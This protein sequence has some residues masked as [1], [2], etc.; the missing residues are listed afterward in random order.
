MLNE[1]LNQEK[2][3]IIDGYL[4]DEDGVCRGPAEL[5]RKQWS[6]ESQSDLEW[7][8][9]KMLQEEAFIAAIDQTDAVL[10]AKAVIANAEAM[11]KDHSN[12]LAGLHW[13]FDNE[14][15]HFVRPLIEGQKS[16]TFKTLVGSVSF[17]KVPGGLRVA[18][19]ESALAVAEEFY[20]ES[21]KVVRSFLVSQLT[22][23]D[24]QEIIE[25]LTTKRD[26]ADR[27]TLKAFEIKPDAET[28]TI[29]TGVA[30]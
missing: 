11:K 7:I 23:E 1:T 4:Y 8:L 26:E 13:R 28:M 17:R 30:K 15:E 16:K 9:N 18:D 19:A 20:P 14:I 29:K 22:E 6:I 5:P 21:V 27:A 24:R 2:L 25:L 3:T 10:H 12:R